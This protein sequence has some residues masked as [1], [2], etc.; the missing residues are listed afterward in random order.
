QYHKSIFNI[1]IFAFKNHRQFRIFYMTNANFTSQSDQSH[2]GTFDLSDKTRGSY[3]NPRNWNE[4]GVRGDIYYYPEYRYYFEFKQSG[5]PA[6]YNWY[7]PTRPQHNDC[8]RFVSG[9]NLGFADWMAV[10][11]DDTSLACI[12]IPGTHDSCT[13]THYGADKSRVRTQNWN[14][15]EQLNNGIRFLDFRCGKADNILL[16][17]YHDTIYLDL[18]FSRVLSDCVNFLKQHPLETLLVR[19]KREGPEISDQEFIARFSNVIRENLD[20]IWQEDR[21]PALGE[22]RQKI[23][24]LSEV[25]GLKGIQWPSLVVE[26]D[27]LGEIFESYIEKKESLIKD[28]LIKCINQNY[29]TNY[30][31]YVTFASINPGTDIFETNYRISEKINPYIFDLLWNGIEID[32]RLGNSD[33]PSL[34]IIPMDFPDDSIKTI[35]S[36]IKFNRNT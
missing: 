7:F 29:T 34:G 36:I 18:D 11:P 14:I 20:Y 28:N 9:I 27:Y 1:I 32:S 15:V 6:D 33:V 12:S 22:V 31:I 2:R 23:V 35:H 3:L 30:N 5:N 13:Y 4:R 26:D 17:M 10:I 25:S 8:W 21:I 19:I 16:G 24:I